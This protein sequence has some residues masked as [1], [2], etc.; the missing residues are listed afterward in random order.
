M[1]PPSTRP[2][3]G[4]LISRLTA[5]SQWE[6]LLDTAREWLAEDPEN[7]SAHRFA[8]QAPVNLERRPEAEPHVSR[9]LARNPDDA[10][11]HR[12]MAIVQYD[13][14]NYGAADKAIRRAIELRPNEAQN[15]YYLAQMCYW[16]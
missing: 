3:R 15:W 2:D 6:R 11:A 10:F 8:A 5:S 13:L 7:P 14:K 9:A 16:Q 4:I 1:T 12:L